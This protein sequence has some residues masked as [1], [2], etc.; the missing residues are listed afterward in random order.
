MLEGDGMPV[1]KH[2][3]LQP[4]EVSFWLSVTNQARTIAIANLI[5]RDYPNTYCQVQIS[6]FG[7]NLHVFMLHGGPREAHIP[8]EIVNQIF[9]EHMAPQLMAELGKI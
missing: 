8:E 9:L 3:N 5:H 4:E 7:K 1:P 6:R 2:E